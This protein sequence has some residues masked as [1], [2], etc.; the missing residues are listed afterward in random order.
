MKLRHTR[1]RKNR[2]ARTRIGAVRPNKKPVSAA[3]SLWPVKQYAIQVFQ[4]DPARVYSIDAV[5]QITG[6]PRRDI[7]IFCKHHLV[8]C[9]DHPELRGYWFTA[10]AVQTLR[11]IERVRSRC[12]NEL[13]SV[14]TILHL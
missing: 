2:S 13:E 8:S 10:D 9:L 6:L 4:P 3:K 5:A 12:H 7:L 1:P 14:A 11:E